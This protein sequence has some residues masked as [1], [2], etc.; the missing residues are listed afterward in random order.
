MFSDTSNLSLADIESSPI[1][2]TA[3]TLISNKSALPYLEKFLEKAPV[4]HVFANL[5]VAF[6]EHIGSIITN[7]GTLVSHH[8]NRL[9]LFIFDF[10]RD[11]LEL[12][13]VAKHGQQLLA[14]PSSANLPQADGSLQIMAIR[15]SSFHWSSLRFLTR[16][17]DSY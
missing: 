9:H 16:R 10:P 11:A 12:S 13:A 15:R 17:F 14:T 5:G 1:I 2:A 4:Y 6:S 8:P 3:F 7:L